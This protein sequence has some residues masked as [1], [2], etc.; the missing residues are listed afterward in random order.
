M[1]EKNKLIQ[2]LEKVN[3]KS[4]L[5]IGQKIGV[6]NFILQLLNQSLSN[7]DLGAKDILDIFG[8]NSKIMYV[9]KEELTE[10]EQEKIKQITSSHE[11]DFFDY[12]KMTVD[13]TFEIALNNN[14][15]HII[16]DN[17][18]DLYNHRKF[19]SFVKKTINEHEKKI[20]CGY[21]SNDK[22][23]KT[24]FFNYMDLIMYVNSTITTS[25]YDVELVSQIN[26]PNFRRKNFYF[27]DID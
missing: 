22:I 12:E 8:L 6:S 27:I 23:L 1:S 19:N 7:Y 5:V 25:S 14:Y 26:D 11:I 2:D 13:S 24:T 17:L 16:F 9:Y 18:K 10:T 3:W 15:S 20:I 4:L 21:Q